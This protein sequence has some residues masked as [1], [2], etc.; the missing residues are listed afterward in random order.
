VLQCAA[1]CCSLSQCVVSPGER[2]LNSCSWG[3]K[4]KETENCSFYLVSVGNVLWLRGSLQKRLDNF[5]T[6]AV[7]RYAGYVVIV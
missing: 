7:I 6:L 5:V 4:L 1:V 3:G 2:P